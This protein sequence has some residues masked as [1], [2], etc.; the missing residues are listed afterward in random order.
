[1][2]NE[3]ENAIFHRMGEQ[4]VE[5]LRTVHPDRDVSVTYD[6]IGELYTFTIDGEPHHVSVNWDSP[7]AGLRDIANQLLSIDF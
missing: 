1:M 4:T 7:S 3:R 5:L 2:K 6:E